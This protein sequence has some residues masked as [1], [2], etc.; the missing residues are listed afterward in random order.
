MSKRDDLPNPF[1]ELTSGRKVPPNR[2]RMK[3]KL[4]FYIGILLVLLPQPFLYYNL[5]M[6]TY[7]IIYEIIAFAIGGL[8]F[9]IIFFALFLKKSR[10][11]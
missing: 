2:T 11:K 10:K 6:E 5:I 4:V 8:G 3:E 1:E 9:I 7:S